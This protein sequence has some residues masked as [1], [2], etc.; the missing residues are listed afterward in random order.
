[1]QDKAYVLAVNTGIIDAEW[2]CDLGSHITTEPLAIRR[3]FDGG[4]APMEAAR[5][6]RDKIP[7]CG[8]CVYE[9]QVTPAIP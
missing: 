8:R 7:P 4:D 6:L 3:L 1:V 9:I 5:V 2:A